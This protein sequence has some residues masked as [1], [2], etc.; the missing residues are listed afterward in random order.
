ML[1]QV[2]DHF[3]WMAEAGTVREQPGVAFVTR[4]QRM[5]NFLDAVRQPQHELNS[6]WN[7]LTRRAHAD[8]TQSFGVDPARIFQLLRTIR[9]DYPELEALLDR[10]RVRLWASDGDSRIGG[11]ARWIFLAG[12]AIYALLFLFSMVFSKVGVDQ[13]DNG[14]V[15]SPRIE[16][17]RP[18][19]TP[20]ER[21]IDV[22]LRSAYGDGVDLAGLRAHN[23]VLAGQLHVLWNRSRG[24][25][26][27]RSGFANQLLKLTNEHVRNGIPRADYSL[28]AEYRRVELDVAQSLEQSSYDRCAAFVAEKLP[29][30]AIPDALLER[31]RAI[32]GRILMETDTATPPPSARAGAAIP[33]EVFQ[34]VARHSGLSAAALKQALALEGPPEAQC[35]ARISLIQALLAAPPEAALDLLRT[36]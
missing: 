32:R 5:L 27:E 15:S 12:L 28:I 31:E 36:M 9:R 29:D 25:D 6:A 4:R 11:V 21:D 1:A 33:G 18:S 26:L 20:E 34:D 35:I 17:E 24:Q 13:T 30:D 10:H 3:G 14:P 22:A 8:S 16:V 7:E 23:P 2:I 19:P